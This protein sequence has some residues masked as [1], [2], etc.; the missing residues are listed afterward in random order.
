MEIRICICV[1]AYCV[2]ILVVLIWYKNML[3]YIHGFVEIS[4]GR[5]QRLADKYGN[6]GNRELNLSL[7]KSWKTMKK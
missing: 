6:I 7:A 3:D 5:A 1:C 2:L 4:S